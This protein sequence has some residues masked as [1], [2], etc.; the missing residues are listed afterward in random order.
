MGPAAMVVATSQDLWRCWDRPPG[1]PIITGPSRYIG[2]ADKPEGFEQVAATL[3]TTVLEAVG[4]EPRFEGGHAEEDDEEGEEEFESLYDESL[5]Q[6]NETAAKEVAA[7]VQRPELKGLGVM[8]QGMK[9]RTKDLYGPTCTIQETIGNCHFKPNSWWKGTKTAKIREWVHQAKPEDCCKKCRETPNCA[10]FNFN[11][12]FGQCILKDVSAKKKGGLK[13]RKGWTAG[14]V[15]EIKCGTAAAAKGTSGK[16]AG[17][18]VPIAPNGCPPRCWRR[19]KMWMTTS[20]LG[21]LVIGVFVFAVAIMD[22]AEL[23]SWLYPG[24]MARST[25]S[26]IGRALTSLTLLIW[27]ILGVQWT[28]G[29]CNDACG[30]TPLWQATGS[31]LLAWIGLALLLCCIMLVLHFTAP[32][33]EVETVPEGVEF[34]GEEGMLYYP[35]DA[36]LAKAMY[37]FPPRWVT[38]RDKSGR[39]VRVYYPPRWAQSPD[40]PRPNVPNQ[41]PLGYLTEDPTNPNQSRVGDPPP[42]TR[43]VVPVASY[44]P[45][46]PSL[47][48]NN[49]HANWR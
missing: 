17:P 9:K 40:Q 3:P 39:T 29:P 20:G 37:Y 32:A 5:A 38:T 34:E 41:T 19:S 33:P 27:F 4:E 31:F 49:R 44:P 30:S 14:A 26:S 47:P 28:W 16:G 6:S 23:K 48:N 22:G 11:P 13:P 45:P 43:A 7:Q 24:S 21:G 15:V 10:Y 46:V 18:N 36:R 42:Y 2:G 12:G 25:I 1:P 8:T 35:T